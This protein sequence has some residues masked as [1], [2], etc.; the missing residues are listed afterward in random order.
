MSE[1]ELRCWQVVAA[2]MR[3]SKVGLWP[4]QT[5]PMEGF[6]DCVVITD[7]R[8][9]RYLQINRVGS[10]HTKHHSWPE[11]RQRCEDD[12]EGLLDEVAQSARLRLGS[13]DQPIVTMPAY[14]VDTI[15]YA[16]RGV[17]GHVRALWD[18]DCAADDFVH[19]VA[20]PYAQVWKELIDGWLDVDPPAADVSPLAWVWSVEVD[21]KPYRLCNLATGDLLGPDGS[22]VRLTL[23]EGEET[24]P[25]SL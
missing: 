11:W 16:L 23:P 12:F 5:W 25:Q 1:T 10:I 4:L 2:L 8:G 20:E 14:V 24:W 19:A 6:Y 17:D 21:G 3:R 15:A 9:K 22:R 13:A 7:R 18:A